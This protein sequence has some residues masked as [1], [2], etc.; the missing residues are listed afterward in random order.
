MSPAAAT[1]A[2]GVDLLGAQAPG[3]G[4]LSP[5]SVSSAL[6]MAGTGATGPTAAQIAEALRLSGPAAFG[7]VGRL[8]RTIAREQAIAGEG[9]PSAP[10]L[11]SAN[12]LFLQQGFPLKP[13]FLD[14]LQKH[15]GATPEVVDFAGNLPASLG[16]INS[17]VSQHTHGIIPELFAELPEDTRLV[18][19]NAVFLKADWLHR[20]SAGNTGPAPFYSSSGSEPVEFMRQTAPL[21]YGA[22]PDYRAVDLPYRASTLSL[23]IVLPVKKKVGALQHDL[24][25]GGLD[26]ITSDL[27]RR[28]VR[29]SLPRFHVNTRTELSQALTSLGMKAVF[30][31]SAEFSGMTSG[32]ELKID[33]VQHVA[34]IRVD[35]AGTVAAAATGVVMT[36]KSASPV[37]RDVVEF[38]ANRP[39]LFFVR[40]KSTGAVLFAGRLADAA[41]AGSG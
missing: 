10:T 38:K 25:A 13:A 15:F 11:E 29:L 41:S 37:P 19:A 24:S 40:D 12:G 32:E 30:G 4:V 18:L 27:A 20:F 39:F 1:G 31:E 23:L 21:S 9:R 22:G 33:T 8:Q 2:F 28:T 16:V 17:W 5:Y 36:P 26:R 6:A 7:A 34:D 35:E 14:G 3:N